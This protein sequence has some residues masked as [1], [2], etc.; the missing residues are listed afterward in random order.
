M[1]IISSFFLSFFLFGQ[2]SAGLFE[3]TLWQNTHINAHPSWADVVESLKVNQRIIRENTSH[4]YSYISQRDTLSSVTSEMDYLLDVASQ[5]RTDISKIR[6]Y[7]SRQYRALRAQL[8]RDLRDIQNR[9]NYL[10]D[11]KRDILRKNS[12][13]TYSISRATNTRFRSA[14][15]ES[16]YKKY[17]YRYD[18]YT[19]GYYVYDSHNKYYSRKPHW[20]NPQLTERSEWYIFIK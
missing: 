6:N 17:N 4:N 2:V 9:I 19:D 7:S 8:Q 5:L 16:Y 10:S 11:R 18:D 15:A 14:R 3:Y 12:Y 1:K 13:N 20:L